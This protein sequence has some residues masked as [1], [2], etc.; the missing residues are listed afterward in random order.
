M[1][2]MA[3]RSRGKLRQKFELFRDRK[4]DFAD[5]FRGQRG[6]PVAG[7]GTRS[8]R[9]TRSVLERLKNQRERA[10]NRPLSIVFGLTL[11]VNANFCLTTKVES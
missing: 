11:K 3:H 7:Q 5:A 4:V 1:P 2:T 9:D 6:I 8:I 10:T